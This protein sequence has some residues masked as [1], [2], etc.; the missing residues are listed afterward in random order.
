MTDHPSPAPEPTLQRTISPVSGRLAPMRLGGL[1]VLAGAILGCGV[2]L[3]A[4]WRAD[5]QRG[6]QDANQAARQVVAFEP[7][8]PSPP[9]LAAPGPNAPSLRQPDQVQVPALQAGARA[10]NTASPSP[11]SPLIAFRQGSAGETAVSASPATAVPRQTTELEGLRQ[12]SA[13]GLA[14][15]RRLPDRNFLILAGSTMPCVLQ[16]AM[17]SATPGYVSCV[18]PRDVLSDSGGVVLLEKGARVM[19]EYRANLRQGDRRLFVLWTRAVTPAGVAVLLASP[20]ADALGRAGFDGEIDTHFWE[21]FGA[22][23]LLSVVDGGGRELSKQD[24]TSSAGRL[25]SDAA[26]VAL[27]TSANIPPT[28]TKPQG[29]EVS[30]FVAQDLDFSGVYDLA[31]P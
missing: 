28:L 10:P 23:M 3:L 29:G 15:A 31:E 25:P 18:I 19:G 1:V 12:G 22:G 26:G 2:L 24:R 14:R 30:I 16:T 5:R 21:R 17:S 11:T 9:T 6:D 20:A 27:Q 7:A 8:P 4:G 13:I